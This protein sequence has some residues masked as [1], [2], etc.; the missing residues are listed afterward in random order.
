MLKLL[1]TPVGNDGGSATAYSLLDFMFRREYG[2]DMPLIEKT[3]AGKPFFPNRADIHF[4]LSHSK[5]HVLCGLSDRLVG[6]DIESPRKLNNRIVAFFT[7][8]EES[9][10]FAPLELWVLKESYIKLIGGTLP[11]VKSIRF[12]RDGKQIITPEDSVISRLYSIDGCTAAVCSHDAVCPDSIE[13]ICGS[14]NLF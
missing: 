14:C 12:S 13:L 11:S 2:C 9:T 8:E 7:S 1:C 4:S 6:V 10:L 3:P 5:T